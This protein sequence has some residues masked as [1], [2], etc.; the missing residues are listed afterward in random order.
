MPAKVEISYRDRI[1][2]K[3]LYETNLLFATEIGRKLE[4][5]RTV[6]KRVLHELGI[7]SR[8]SYRPPAIGTKFNSGQLKV[9]KL[10]A[11]GMGS[12]GW[13]ETRVQVRCK[14]KGPRSDFI[15]AAYKLRSGNVKSCGC[16]WLGSPNY[17]PHPDREWHRILKTYI[18]NHPDFALNLEQIKYICKRPCF[19]CGIPPNNAL[20][21]RHMRVTNRQVVLWYSGIDE[22]IHG[23]GHVVGNV[24]PACIICNRAKSNSTLEEWC[25]YIRVKPAKIIEGTR[26]IAKRLKKIPNGSN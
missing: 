3:K 14:C 13:L 5:T 19:Y 4:L 25:R 22:V 9:I 12:N 23:K 26:Q 15:V 7:K 24:L 1:R 2:I 17:R 16:T 11:P 10:A 20:M 18:N 6:V 8:G 21:G